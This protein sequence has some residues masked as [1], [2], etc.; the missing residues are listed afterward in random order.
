MYLSYIEQG[1]QSI[2]LAEIPASTSN[3]AYKAIR[4]FAEFKNPVKRY[5]INIWLF[6]NVYLSSKIVSELESEISEGS[7]VND[8]T[9]AIVAAHILNQSGVSFLFRSFFCL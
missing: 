9:N 2:P 4:R 7:F 5:V 8:E 6:K 1:K 3:T